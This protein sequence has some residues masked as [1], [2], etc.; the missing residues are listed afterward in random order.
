[1]SWSADVDPVVTSF[2]TGRLRR[3]VPITVTPPAIELWIDN[4]IHSTEAPEL[5]APEPL[6]FRLPLPIFCFDAQ[7]HRIEIRLG[8][9]THAQCF[10]SEYAGCIDPFSD[11]VLTGWATDY[12][13]PG[14][15]IEIDISI[16]GTQVSRISANVFRPDLNGNCGF[17][18]LLRETPEM[19]RSFVLCARIAWTDI[20]LQRSP[21]LSLSR[22]RLVKAA[23]QLNSAFQYLEQ[24]L[25]W[26]RDGRGPAF[27]LTPAERDTFADLL[28]QGSNVADILE[29]RRRFLQPMQPNLTEHY[30]RRD[31]ATLGPEYPQSLPRRNRGSH[32]DRPVDIIV[33]IYAGLRETERCLASV[34]H[35][36]V[37]CRYQLICV[38]DNPEAS[39]IAEMVGRLAEAHPQITVIR[40]ESN[41]GF[42]ESVNRA[43][44]LHRDRDVVI[45][46][47][48]CE[49]H[50]D[51]LL[52]LQQ[53]A[54]NGA[55]AGLVN[56]M[57]NYAEFLSYPAPWFIQPDDA[58]FERLDNFA[59][60]VNAGLTVTIPAATAF[61]LFVRRGCLDDLGFF[62][63]DRPSGGY[64]AEKYFSVN[65]AAQGWRT[66]LAADVFVKHH[67]FVSFLHR[68]A[69]A[70]AEAREA[71]ELWCPFYADSVTDFLVDDP[72][73]PARRELDLARL[74][75]LGGPVFCF[76]AHGG[77]GGTERHLQD[78]TEALAIDG[79]RTISMFAWPDRRVSLATAF[80]DSVENIRYRLDDEFDR[81]VS[82]LKRL[83]IVHIH[84]HSNVD[85]P[86]ELFS[87]PEVLGVP[88]DITVHDY[89]WF[90]PQVTLVNRSGAY[91]GEPPVPVC[92]ICT[93]TDV[94]KLRQ[95][96]RAR[97]AQARHVF[98]PSEDTRARM[99]R[100]FQLTNLVLRP[101]PEWIGEPEWAVTPLAPGQI[102]RVACIGRLS[103]HKG[104]KVVR[105]CAA[106]AL[107]W[108][109][110]LHFV[111]IGSTADDAQFEGL[112]NLEITGPYEDHE[113]DALIERHGIHVAFLPSL[114]PET[115]S[116]TLSIAL[117]CGLTPVAFDL[118]AIADRIKRDDAGILL[119][120]GATALQLNEALLK[121]GGRQ[122]R[123]SVIRGT[124]YLNMLRDYYDM[125]GTESQT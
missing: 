124:G 101:H 49:V 110:P 97:L 20:D 114:W 83:H 9:Q 107:E 74:E 54:Y 79:I 118:G 47:A 113:A 115:Y 28:L 93:G 46:H 91:C 89:A 17:H 71:F 3:L 78:L 66:I 104:L 102:V 15:P 73:L 8:D 53:A 25:M 95:L 119:P 31:F 13:R 14:I 106:H 112:S 90:C 57:T 72:S 42:A 34:L 12:A 36:P 61:C 75:S 65:A 51:W 18:H 121:A 37:G 43:M 45:L 99:E 123:N 59:R 87:L 109:L 94:S 88:H 100:Q 111:I 105:E 96:S 76:I 40:N 60:S 103:G 2:V 30:A 55:G 1:V 22:P 35:S 26:N 68:D 29:L 63:N 24:L 82:D 81:L 120:L 41:E 7:Q 67:G 52:R 48:D 108:G 23:Q 6:E 11:N 64:Y 16:N 122:P 5:G 92:D 50:G 86:Q 117:R 80:L 4:A 125:G 33:P 19:A 21:V 56:P 44:R 85:V 38:L 32:R 58:P 62:H 77:G 27:Q 69:D 10:Q 116:Y 39:A 98:C 70:V 84:I